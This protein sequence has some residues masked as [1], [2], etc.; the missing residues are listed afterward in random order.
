MRFIRGKCSRCGGRLVAEQDLEHGHHRIACLA[1]GKTVGYAHSAPDAERLRAVAE[2]ERREEYARRVSCGLAIED[3]NL[4]ERAAA[5]LRRAGI[6]HVSNLPELPLSV[7]L[8]ARA[9]DR[10]TFGELLW[11]LDQEGFT[12]VTPAAAP[13][14]PPR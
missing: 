4:S 3:L 10:R 9:F 5:A 14:P 1:C 11:L 7:L 12:A 13:T 8:A 2:R 6:T